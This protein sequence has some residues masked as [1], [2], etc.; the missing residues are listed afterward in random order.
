[1]AG[2][3][4]FAN[5]FFECIVGAWHVEHTVFIFGNELLSFVP[6]IAQPRALWRARARE[7]SPVTVASARV[8]EDGCR[9]RLKNIRLFGA[10]REAGATRHDVRWR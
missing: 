3:A 4:Y 2:T 5:I 9:V 1:M 7:S 10:R 8:Y 6:C